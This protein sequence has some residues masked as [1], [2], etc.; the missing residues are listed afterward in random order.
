MLS[1]W[2]KEGCSGGNE[3][4]YVYKGTADNFPSAITDESIWESVNYEIIQTCQY[5]E[6]DNNGN[7]SKR[8]VNEV[9]KK[10]D[11]D[12]ESSET[13]NYIETATYVCY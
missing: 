11:D 4:K 2:V 5:M 10:S 6:F 12:E 13:R 1:H 7:W 9:S 8:K 3:E